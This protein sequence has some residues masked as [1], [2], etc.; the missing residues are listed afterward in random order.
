M[1]P[2]PNT[3]YFSSSI[4]LCYLY[5]GFHFKKFHDWALSKISSVGSMWSSITFPLPSLNPKEGPNIYFQNREILNRTMTRTWNKNMSH[6]GLYIQLVT[7]LLNI[8]PRFLSEK[9]YLLPFSTELSDFGY[10]K[11]GEGDSKKFASKDPELDEKT[12]CKQSCQTVEI[13]NRLLE[14]HALKHFPRLRSR[15][16]MLY[17]I[18]QH[19]SLGFI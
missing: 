16:T 8:T 15:S 7:P 1:F 5:S 9:T 17:F 6:H 2:K 12:K 13:E 11:R 10:R 14:S 18:Q 19:C 4:I 3:T